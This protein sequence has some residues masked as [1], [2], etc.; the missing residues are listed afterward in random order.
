VSLIKTHL[1]PSYKDVVACETSKCLQSM[2]LHPFSVSLSPALV[3]L[4]V[5]LRPFHANP[6]SFGVN[7]SYLRT[8]RNL[9]DK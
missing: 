4:V 8:G 9:V 7:I 6:P 5:S 1:I 3:V 2:Q